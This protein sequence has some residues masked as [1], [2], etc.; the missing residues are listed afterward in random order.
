MR[1]I[2]AM[3]WVIGFTPGSGRSDGWLMLRPARF[4][5]RMVMSSSPAVL[6]RWIAL[7][8]RRLR[9]EVGYERKEVARHLGCALSRI[10]HLETARD[11]PKPD[12]LKQMLS[13][14]GRSERLD[15]FL[16]LLDR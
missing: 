10:G 12:D 9:E 2:S 3:R 7:E 14:Y 8:L 15:F 6:R 11:P 4:R 1:R 16:D 5:R 13:Y